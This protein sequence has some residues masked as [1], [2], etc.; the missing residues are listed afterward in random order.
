MLLHRLYFFFTLLIRY[1]TVF[2][3]KTVFS[4]LEHM[5][6]IRRLRSFFSFFRLLA[7]N[8][9]GEIQS[10]AFMELGRVQYL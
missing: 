7:D 5:E 1:F 3:C 6:D 4:F 10:G 2:R 8:G 9:I